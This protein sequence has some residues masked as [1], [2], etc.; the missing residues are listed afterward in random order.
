MLTVY[1]LLWC[2]FIQPSF[3]AHT[4]YYRQIPWKSFCINYF[5][6]L[7]SRSFQ[8]D[9][10]SLHYTDHTLD[11]RDHPVEKSNGYTSFA[12]LLDLS[13][14]FKTVGHF[15][16]LEMLFYLRYWNTH[17][18]VSSISYA[19]TQKS[20]LLQFLLFYTSKC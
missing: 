10:F 5:H 12:I 3:Q 6:F 16:R 17:P 15:L 20:L 14:T 1:D 18:R 7:I 4:L 9:F 19:I 2:C 13:E 8:Y 11:T